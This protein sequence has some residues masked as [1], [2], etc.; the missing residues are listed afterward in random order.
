MS[1]NSVF[2]AKLKY[3]QLDS[4]Q[5]REFMK[6]VLDGTGKHRTV[7]YAWLRGGNTPSLAEQNVV[8]NAMNEAGD[9]F[10]ALTKADLFI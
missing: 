1:D 9:F 2:P 7:I 10:P 6:R 4:D 5:K 8:V 3:L